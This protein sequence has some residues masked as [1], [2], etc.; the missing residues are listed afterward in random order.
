[1]AVAEGTPDQQQDDR[2]E[3]RPDDARQLHRAVVDVLTEKQVSEEPARKAAQHAEQP[4]AEQTH[5]VGTRHQQ[6]GQ[7]TGEQTHDEQDDTF[8]VLAGVLTVQ[9]NDEIFDLAAG[10]FATVPPGIPHTFDNVRKDQAS[11]KVANLMT[12]GGLDETFLELS[13]LGDGASAGKLGEIFARHGVRRI[14][15]TIG[16]KLGLR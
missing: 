4:G 12:P 15:P 7:R 13:Q 1:M 6:T 10:D 2:P 5:R 3:D 14:G 11:V 16:Q 9:V 8:F